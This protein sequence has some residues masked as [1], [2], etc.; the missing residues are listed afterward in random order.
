MQQMAAVP[1][2]IPVIIANRSSVYLYGNRHGVR[3]LNPNHL[4]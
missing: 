2:D 3:D 1:S 4:F